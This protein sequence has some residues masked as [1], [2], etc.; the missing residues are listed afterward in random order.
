MTTIAETP[1]LPEDLL[2]AWAKLSGYLE[3][4]FESNLHRFSM[5]EAGVV[6]SAM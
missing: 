5:Q 1:V 4:K 2:T 3:E 6:G